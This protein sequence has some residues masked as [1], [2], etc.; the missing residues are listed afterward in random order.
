MTGLRFA[1]HFAWLA[2]KTEGVWYH[3][4]VWPVQAI[5]DALIVELATGEAIDM[6]VPKALQRAAELVQP[7]HDSVFRFSHCTLLSDSSAPMSAQWFPDILVHK[8]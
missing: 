4:S 8:D 1:Y 3:H 5:V 6:K 2:S 7:K